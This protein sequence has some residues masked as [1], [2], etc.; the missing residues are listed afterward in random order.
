M[1][2][3]WNGCWLLGRSE[4]FPESQEV[5]P[6]ALGNPGGVCVVGAGEG[7][8]PWG[9]SGLQMAPAPRVPSP[10][11]MPIRKRSSSCGRWRMRK[12]RTA[13]S[14]ARAMR[15]TSR[16]CSSPFLTGSPDTTM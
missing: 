15:A 12:E 8:V 4:V 13:S 1:V 6:E 9:Q 3:G 14:S 16:A 11:W 5:G 10:V 2:G 7:G